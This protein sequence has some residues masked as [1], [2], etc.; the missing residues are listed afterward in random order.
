MTAEKYPNP[1]DA[2]KDS[3]KGNA[4]HGAEVM[5]AARR[6]VQE[7]GQD[8]GRRGRA[9]APTSGPRSEH[10]RMRARGKGMIHHYLTPQVLV[11]VIRHNVIRVVDASGRPGRVSSFR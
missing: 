5:R 6:V 4:R 7:V 3:G 9:P 1:G 11:V 8:L 2:E 10:H